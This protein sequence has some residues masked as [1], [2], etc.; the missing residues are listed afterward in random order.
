MA[1]APGWQAGLDRLPK[2]AS[3]FELDPRKTALVVIDMQYL[4]AH[5]DYGLGPYLRRNYPESFSYYFGRVASTVLP[6]HLKL[7]EFFRK[8]GL[9]VIY[10]A[11]GPLLADRSDLTPSRKVRESG[12]VGG[13]PSYLSPVG[14]FEHQ[15][16]PEIA[17]QQGELVLDKN[18]SSPFSS[19]AIDQLLRNMGIEY[20]VV[21]GVLTFACVLLTAADAADRGYRCVVVEDAVAGLDQAHHEAT[22]RV[23]AAIYGRVET[24][25]A[26]CAEMQWQLAV[27]R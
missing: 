7:L 27:V 15:V 26:V 22:L 23:F 20:L 2:L 24:T 11:A 4:D 18:S 1:N 8:N 19:T 5:P 14:S 9:R 6:N 3:V 16:L 17:P 12:K 10:L 21:T 25:E 13:R